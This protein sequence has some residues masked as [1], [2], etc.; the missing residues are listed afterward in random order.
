MKI[1]TRIIGAAMLVVIVVNIVYAVYFI[2]KERRATREQLDVNVANNEMMLKVVTAGPLYDG[3]V[4]QLDAILDS[5]FT[6][7]DITR[8]YLQEYQGN[9][10]MY[11]TRS[12]SSPT[13]VMIT[14]K[15]VIRRNIDELGE[16]TTEYSTSNIEQRLQ[17]SRNN[18][19]LLSVILM[20][21][22]SGVTFVVARGLTRPIERL[23]AA[24]R[25]MANG[26]LEQKIDP[27][28]TQELQSLGQSF[29][30]MRDAVQEKMADLAARN[31]A[32]R[33]SEDRLRTVVE[34]TPVV[35]FALDQQ[36]RFI[37]SEGKGLAALGLQSGQVVGQSALEVYRESPSALSGIRRALAGEE[38]SCVA[39]VAEL[40]YEVWY[41]PVRNATGE[42]IGTIGVA[43]DITERKQAEEDREKLQSQ[44]LQSQKMESIGQL[45]GGIA[46]DFNNILAAI[47]GYGDILRRKMQNNDPSREYVNQILTSAERAASLTQSLLAFSRKQV[48]S[49]RDIDL[50]ESVRKVENLLA[51]IIGEDIILITA[52]SPEVLII[53]ADITQIEQALMNLATNARDAMPTGGRLMIET[54][55]VML[56]DVY[57]RTKGYGLPGSYAMLKISDT[58]EG[59]DEQTQKKI[60]EPFF[61]TK[62][63]GRG[64]GLGLAIVYG[65]VK[66]NN[67]YINVYSEVGKGT[68]FTIYLPL[69]SSQARENWHPPVPQSLRGGT[70][71]ILFAEDNATIRML[72]RDVL[73]EFGYT[74]IEATDG[75]EALQKFREHGDRIDLLILDIIMPKKNGKEVFEGIRKMNANIK[76]IFTSGY[77]A[78]LIQ[79]EDVIEQGLHFLPKPSPPQA[80]LRMVREVLDQ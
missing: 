26:H 72:S 48:I 6:D 54:G 76:A 27:G 57:I 51:R 12:L 53:F 45:A 73:Q 56:D 13:G 67:G 64:T 11:R 69:V 35:F 63:L 34:N 79:K 65:I 28:G 23:T 39:E 70:E 80:L 4:E 49:P 19:L 22:L 40:V 38:F 60:F 77:P 43:T 32:L 18:I 21:G 62:Q 31:E 44:L 20:L 36:G 1:Q 50:N 46:H 24:A 7:P 14:S 37:L 5:L 75:E 61:T 25:E 8:I 68:T 78:D 41:S 47:V 71:T 2:G 30:R 3:N 29:I 9:I 55:Q 42:L 17:Q 59:I 52:L 15:V 16:I 74:V 33:T 10:R 66:Q 58:G